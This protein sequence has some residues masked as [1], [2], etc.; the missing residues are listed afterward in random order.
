MRRIKIIVVIAVLVLAVVAG[1]QIGSCELANI[2]LQEDLRDL[3]SPAVTRY[4]YPSARSDD[5]FRDAVIH[6]AKEHDIKLQPNQVTVE[7]RGSGIDSTVYLA[8]EYS[9]PVNLR[10]YSFTLHFT[11]SSTKRAF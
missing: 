4:G 9:V 1:W 3:A 7:R 2:Q 8:A 5:D 6:K 11:P 10:W